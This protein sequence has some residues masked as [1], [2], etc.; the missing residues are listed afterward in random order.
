METPP[1]PTPQKNP[2]AVLRSQLQSDLEVLVMDARQLAS[3]VDELRPLGL[4]HA[5]SFVLTARSA[6]LSMRRLFEV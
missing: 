6:L 4:P 2:E 5:V 1:L 3:L